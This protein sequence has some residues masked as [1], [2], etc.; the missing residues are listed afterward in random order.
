MK[1]HKGDC[2][3][4]PLISCLRRLSSLAGNARRL[5][6]RAAAK[7]QRGQEEDDEHN[8]EN[9]RDTRRSTRDTRKAEEPGNECDQEEHN[10]PAQHK[11][12]FHLCSLVVV[13]TIN[14]FG[15]RLMSVV[16]VNNLGHM[17]H[18]PL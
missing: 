2:R 16:V 7:D 1:R 10:G 17:T 11:I 8:E 9:L 15:F 14:V 5:D 18:L 13:V 6:A 4:A 12:A 3:S